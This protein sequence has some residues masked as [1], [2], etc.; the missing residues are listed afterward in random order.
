MYGV[1][2]AGVEEDSLSCCCLATVDVCLI[3]V[4]TVVDSVLG[5]QVWTNG[6]ANVS[7]S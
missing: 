6:N 4:S 7:H 3:E 1:D 2:S 5:F